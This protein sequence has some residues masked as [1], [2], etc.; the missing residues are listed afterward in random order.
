MTNG[1]KTNRTALEVRGKYK[2]DENILYDSQQGTMV[3]TDNQ[4]HVHEL[5]LSRKLSTHSDGRLFHHCVGEIADAAGVKYDS[6]VIIL[7]RLFDEG[8][9]Y[10]N[11]LLNLPTKHLYAFVINNKALL[12]ADFKESSHSGIQGVIST[13]QKNTA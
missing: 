5:A 4:E 12:K 9:K 3:V 8:V 2:F 13:T 1:V 7:R 10:S 11:K 6:M